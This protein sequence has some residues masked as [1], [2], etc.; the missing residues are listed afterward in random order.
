MTNKKIGEYEIA[1]V[2]GQGGMGKIYKGRHP[3]IKNTIIIKQLLVSTK[4][5]LTK[6]FERE[7]DIMS[8]F[9]HPNIVKVYEQF[10]VGNSYYISMEFIDGLSLEDLIK[11]KN[12]ISPLA[13]VLIFNECCKGLKYAHDKGVI[14]R[15]IKPDNILIA[16]SGKVKL[17]DFGIATSQP[18]KDEEL[19]KTGIV[20]G[21]PAY[22]SPEQLISTKYVD[23]RSDIYSMGVMFYQMITGKRPFPSTFTADTISKISKGL[24]TKPEKENPDIPAYFKTVIKKTMNCKISKRYKDLDD[25]ITFLSKYTS[26]FEKQTDLHRAIKNYLVGKELTASASRSKVK[27]AV[28]KKPASAVKKPA[29]AV[30]NPASAAKKPASAAKKPASAAKK[31]A[32]AVKKPAS[33]AKK[34]ASAAKKPASAVKK[35]ASASDAKT[36]DN[37]KA[38]AS[39]ARKA[40]PSQVK[41]PAVSSSHPLQKVVYNNKAYKI[42]ARTTIGREA[43]NNIIIKDDNLVSRKH[44]SIIKEGTK[45]YI[46]AVGNNGTFLNSKKLAN[47]KKTIIK[48][49][50]VIALGKT[51]LFLS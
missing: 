26:D 48:G 37:K 10:K 5:I 35:P 40:S 46:I 44:A 6:R 13:A 31:P 24:Y 29:S 1:E 49:G 23:V 27:A 28:P 42:T 51:K 11:E 17:C 20:M 16:K 36:T 8:S 19:T 33:A 39:A 18:G 12:V 34:P 45:Y 41:K 47:N 15:D 25:L 30:K 43:N 2:I 21:T 3:S 14:H 22:M 32:S 38:A 9:S 7:A 50:D 4:T